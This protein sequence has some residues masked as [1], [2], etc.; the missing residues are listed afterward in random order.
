MSAADKDGSGSEREDLAE[1]LARRALT[2]DAA[3]PEA[4]EKRHAT[5]ARTAREN[6]EDLVEPGSFVEYGRFAIAAQRGRR[7]LDDLIART[8]ADGMIGGT[9]RVNEDLFGTEGSACAV[10]SY[11]YTV[12]AGTQG[13]LG[14]KKK[15]RLF[16]LIERMRLPT[17]FYAEGGG[18]RPGD[19]D[20]PVVSALDVRAFA[21]WAKLSGLVPRIAIVAGRCFAGNAVIAG[22]AD[23]IVATEGSSLGMGG[24]AM[25]EGGGLGKVDPDDVGPVEMQ[26]ANGVVD[27]VVADE[28]A[29]TAATR[30]LLAYFQGGTE[31]GPAPDQAALRDLVPERQ[32]RAYA[33]APIVETLADEGSVTFLREPFAPEMATALCRIE[34]MPVGVIANDTRHMAGAITS[35]AGDKSARFLQLCDA[36]GIPVLSLVDTPGMMV[37]PKAEATGLVRHTSRLLVAGAAL[38]V[39]LLAVI[40]RRGYGL[41]A[42]AMVGGGL[43]EPLLTVAWPTAHLGPMGLEGAVRLALRKELEEIA[44][45]AEREQRVRDLTAQAEENAKALNAAALFELDDVIDPAETRSLIASTLRA[46]A[47]SAATPE[48]PRFV[49]TW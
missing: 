34:G 33:V 10:L 13:A 23:L 38:R 15:D 24:P 27:L 20:Y 35:E 14:H 25:I 7:E 46:A 44:D 12:L 37:G 11:D 31:P 41:G 6:V 2:E 5:G 36:F 26:A 16:E 22:C 9:A 8:P 28:V 30:K 1:L 18:G 32:R 47:G 48:R 3:R 19:T 43:H 45:E 40:L 4:V 39:P 49:D 17:V 29:A 21:L 42:Q